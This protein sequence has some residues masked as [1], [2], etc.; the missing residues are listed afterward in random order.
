MGNG[1]DSESEKEAEVGRLA[2]EGH[3]RARRTRD[4]SQPV[5]VGFQLYVTSGEG[6]PTILAPLAAL[7]VA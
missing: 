4:E 7:N 5:I 3:N 2:R 1:R 6:S